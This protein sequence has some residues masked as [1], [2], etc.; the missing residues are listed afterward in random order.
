MQLTFSA[1]FPPLVLQTVE[2]IAQHEAGF[3]SI[4][5]GV[6]PGR[7]GLMELLQQRGTQASGQH[8]FSLGR[9][10]SPGLVV[11]GRTEGLADE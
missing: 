10:K 5:D 2:T 11:E 4:A 8:A 6:T 3:H 9:V 1:C 7:Q